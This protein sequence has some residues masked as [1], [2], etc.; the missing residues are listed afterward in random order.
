MLPH[1][2]P[3]AKAAPRQQQGSIILDCPTCRR[4]RARHGRVAPNGAKAR[5]CAGPVARAERKARSRV[6]AARRTPAAA[7]RGGGGLAPSAICAPPPP[8]GAQRLAGRVRR[9]TQQIYHIAHLP[10]VFR[11]EIDGV[12]PGCRGA[13][14]GWWATPG[15][16]GRALYRHDEAGGPRPARRRRR[17]TQ[18]QML[19]Q[20]GGGPDQRQPRAAP[21]L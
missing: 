8:G 5:V 13:R 3:L 20:T 11:A 14:R 18:G 10:Q 16:H 1:Q 6:Q 17:S 19:P 15:N 9:Q 4:S 12:V 7:L 2:F 21:R